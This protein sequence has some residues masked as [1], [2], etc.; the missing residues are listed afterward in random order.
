MSRNM[1]EM[2]IP[3]RLVQHLKLYNVVVVKSEL[4]GSCME[5]HAGG[6]LFCTSQILVE[7]VL[8]FITA[9]HADLESRRVAP[10]FVHFGLRFKG[11]NLYLLSYY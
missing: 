4:Q 10:I 7:C 8:D 2:K 11:G 3:R 1:T 5:P 6:K 9:Q